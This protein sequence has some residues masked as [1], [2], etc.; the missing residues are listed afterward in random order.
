MRK[1]LKI[2]IFLFSAL[3]QSFAQEINNRDSLQIWYTYMDRFIQDAEAER[4]TGAEEQKILQFS[5]QINRS[6]RLKN[7]SALLQNMSSNDFRDYYP[8]PGFSKPK[9]I[10]QKIRTQFKAKNGDEYYYL[11]DVKK[12]VHTE[13]DLR[14]NPQASLNLLGGFDIRKYLIAY[15]DKLEWRVFSI[16]SDDQS[17]PIS[18]GGKIFVAFF[19]IPDHLIYYHRNFAYFI[20]ERNGKLVWVGF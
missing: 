15:N 14:E 13:K 11:F 9:N 7:I 19:S 12:F 17:Y 6:I 3:I 4:V 1:I 10:V 2:S 18:G 16:Q 8:S 20:A 5:K